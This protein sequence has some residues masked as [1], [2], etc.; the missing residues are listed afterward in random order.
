MSETIPNSTI[1]L[2]SFYTSDFQPLH[3]VT[4]PVKDTYCA[5]HGYRH[6]VKVAPYGNPQD[7]YAFQRIRYLRDLLFGGLPEGDGIEAVLVLNSHAQVM[8][9]TI[10]V[11]SF[12]DE[13]HDFYIA[14]DVNG[15]NAGVF[16]VRKSEWL[17]TWLD[18]LL[19]HESIHHNFEWKEQ[20]LVTMFWKLPQFKLRISLVDQWLLNGY[21]WSHY[22]WPVTTPGQF[23]PGKSFVLHIPGRSVFHPEPTPLVQTRVKLFSSPE[24]V[25]NIVWA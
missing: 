8:T 12:I 22:N 17:K 4:G 21:L 7:Y 13:D 25:D 2:L 1:A 18:H 10:M 11:Q 5:K 14:A 16:I 24:V 9:H 20:S 23:R 19:A 3:D 15:L 6:I